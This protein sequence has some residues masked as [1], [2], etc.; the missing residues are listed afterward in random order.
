[1]AAESLSRR[2]FVSGFVC[3]IPMF[4]IQA[5]GAQQTS[6]RF[7]ANPKV[8]LLEDGRLVRLIE[9]F[10]FINA[11]GRGWPV[12]DGT[13]S[14]GASIPQFFWS[15]IGGPFEGLYRGPS[16][17]HDYY[18]ETRTRRSSDVHSMF[19]SA[20]LCAHVGGRRAFLMYEAVR[21]FGPSWP[22]PT[23]RP[24]QCDTPTADY[25]FEL[26]TVNSAPPPASAP[27]ITKD[28]IESFLSDMRGRADEAD[29]LQLQRK[30]DRR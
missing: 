17:V 21:R 27:V 22:D 15:L 13:I 3:A 26:C 23:P 29:L 16:I 20:M 25:D 28:N 24:P 14:D 11:D 7:S 6:C 8:E 30:I 5:A 10:E 12:P 18:C 19:H 2:G 1:M 4:R 9:R